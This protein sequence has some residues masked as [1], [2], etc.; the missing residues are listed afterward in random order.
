[1]IRGQHCPCGKE[2]SEAMEDE[3]ILELFFTRSEDAIAQVKEKYGPACMHLLRNLLLSEQDAEECANDAY[4]ALWDTIP[5]QRPQKLL[6]YL[7]KI[8]R[9]QGLRR[10]T[11]YNAQ[12]REKK[13]VVALEELESCIASGETVEQALDRK[14]LEE[15]IDR[16]L[17]SLPK[18]ERLLFLRR[19]WFCDSVERLAELF[20]WSNSKVKSKLFRLR[21]RLRKHLQQEGFNP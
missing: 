9:N 20:G 2:V 15:E 18:E 16:F 19:Y 10:I 4:L 11:Y 12:C 7:L 5:P 8:A 17:R 3:Q 1:M 13:Q 6:T 14:L 21:A